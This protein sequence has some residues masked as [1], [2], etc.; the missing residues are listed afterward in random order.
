MALSYINLILSLPVED[1]NLCFQGKKS[2]FLVSNSNQIGYYKTLM[3]DLLHGK[4]FLG[5]INNC[6]LKDKLL[7]I[8][9][10]TYF[11]CYRFI[12]ASY[13]NAP[14]MGVKLI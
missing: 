14:T 7:K 6:Y 4:P 12:H 10:Y 5:K 9:L 8:Y 1:L 2:L 3:V 11:Y 13:K